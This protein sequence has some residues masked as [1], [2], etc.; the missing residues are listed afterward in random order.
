MKW[1][2]DKMPKR[3]HVYPLND[4]RDHLIGDD[5]ECWCNPVPDSEYPTLLV[6]NS[7]DG[8]EQYETKERKSN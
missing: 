8:R 1:Q 2:V 5:D 4:L 7:M 6:H 3:I